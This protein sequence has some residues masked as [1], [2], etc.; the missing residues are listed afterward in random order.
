LAID[1]SL[2][3]DAFSGALTCATGFA[4]DDAVE[5]LVCGRLLIPL[6]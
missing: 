2:A 3:L 5:L 4:S 6:A 1:L